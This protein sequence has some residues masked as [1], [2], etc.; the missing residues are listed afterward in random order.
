M[1]DE[2]LKPT[3]DPY[4]NRL[5]DEVGKLGVKADHVTIYGFIIGIV[6]CV[7][8][9]LQSYLFGLFLILL[10]RL[11]DGVDGAVARF[12]KAQGQPVSKF[13]AYLDVILDMI[14]FGAF[15]FLFVLG[16]P[17]HATA[18]VFI[19]F[20]YV[21]LFATALGAHM[22][23]TVEN[24]R[25]RPFYHPVNLVEGSE[26]I[27]FMVLVCLYPYAFSAIAVVFGVFCWLTTIARIIFTYKDSK[28]NSKKKAE[29]ITEEPV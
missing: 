25:T 23:G 29:T 10:N 6:G 11:C 3:I 9:G 22:I 7:F 26:I 18:A 13:G 14:L 17:V 21:G 4:L 12:N 1:F 24:N 5:A 27:L 16:Q 20:S 28:E 2:K 8:I 19:L 15:I